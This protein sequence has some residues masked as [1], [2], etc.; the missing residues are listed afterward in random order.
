MRDEGSRFRDKG[1]GFRG[2]AENQIE[3]NMENEMELVLFQGL[4]RF[5]ISP[6]PRKRVGLELSV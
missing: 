6:L 3:K 1:L 4:W 2:R 5:P